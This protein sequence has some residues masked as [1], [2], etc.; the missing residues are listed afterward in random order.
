MARSVSKKFILSW[1]SRS[2]GLSPYS[3]NLLD[4]FFLMAEVAIL[5]LQFQKTTKANEKVRIANVRQQFHALTTTLFKSKFGLVRL[6]FFCLIVI[7]TIPASFKFTVTINLLKIELK[8]WLQNI[9]SSESAG[10]FVNR[11]G[12]KGS[13]PIL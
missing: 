9:H 7:N 13:F 3:Q 8:Y 5:L 4:S 11:T 1:D 12:L 10:E 6:G 2:F